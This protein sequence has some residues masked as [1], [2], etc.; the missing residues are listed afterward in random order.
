MN[1]TRGIAVIRFNADKVNPVFLNAA[2]NEPS[3][4][5]FIQ[6]HTRGATLKEFLREEL[7]DLMQFVTGP[8]TDP[9]F[10]LESGE[11]M[12]ADISAPCIF[13]LHFA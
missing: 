3:S 4:Q 9:I 11:K 12:S 7:R 6:E 5:T 2:I 10:I 8:K 1:V 13:F